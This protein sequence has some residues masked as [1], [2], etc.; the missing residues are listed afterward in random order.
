MIQTNV[1]RLLAAVVAIVCISGSSAYP[2]IIFDN[3]GSNICLKES[4]SKLILHNAAKVK[5]WE[6]QSI[7]KS[8]GNNPSTAWTES[9]ASGVAIGQ[10][11]DDHKPSTYFV[12][13]NSNAIVPL[14]PTNFNATIGQRY[15]AGH[16]VFH[17]GEVPVQGFIRFNDGFTV[18]HNASATW[19]SWV[20]VRGGIDLRETGTLIL[21]SPMYLGSGFTFTSGGNIVGNSS[22]IFMGGD[23]TLA[24]TGG[25]RVIHIKNNLVID[26]G[27]S[28]FNVGSRAQLFVD[29][30]VSLTLRNLTL[31][32]GPLS[33]ATPAVKLGALTS[34]LT[35]DNVVFELGSDY[36]FGG[37]SLFINNDVMVT[38]TSAFIYSA[39]F[40]SY[41]ASHSTWYFD[42]GTTL[43]IAPITHTLNRANV[44][45]P[46][47]ENDFI[48]MHD[49][50]SRLFLN[51]ASLLSTTTGLRLTR[52]TL[53]LDNKV[54]MDSHAERQLVGLGK[55]V[56]DA[57]T[58][59]FPYW[60]Y[61]SPDGRYL[62]VANSSDQNMQIFAFNGTA[63]TLVGQLPT[64]SDVDSINWSPDGRFIAVANYTAQQLEIFTFSGKGALRRVGITPTTGPVNDVTWSPDCRY[65]GVV[66]DD[67]I[68]TLQIFAFNG[69]TINLVGT[70]ATE[71]APYAVDWAPDG[72]YLV[73]VNYLSNSGQ[74]FAFMG[75][76]DPVLVLQLPTDDGP[77]DVAVSPDGTY[78]A[79]AC[80][81]GLTV[82][83]FNMAGQIGSSVSPGNTPSG[84]GWS[85]TGRYI[86]VPC[87]FDNT[88]SVY[89]FDPGGTMQLI[90]SS[91][92]CGAGAKFGYFS[93]DGNHIAVVASTDN[94][95]QLFD[96]HYGDGIAET[97]QP[98]TNAINFGHAVKGPDYDLNVRM[99][100]GARVLVT[101]Q[102]CDDSA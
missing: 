56:P 42:Y 59:Q 55:T 70:V 43:S 49:V 21:H 51:G 25:Y 84:V 33:A 95:L 24:A 77:Y 3:F 8:Y 28:V 90:G 52:G 66:N 20:P 45:N 61:W 71:S 4:D 101:G 38:G 44:L 76:A 89:Q 5:G 32:T 17:G 93:P 46:S 36:R 86:A 63:L 102:V 99:L 87:D 67:P 78:A 34:H 74:L 81:G 41:I 18:R 83:V 37:G 14:L 9:Y 35:L 1:L 22:T 6:Q 10:S 80:Y 26:G 39:P 60:A 79:I 68:N 19:D 91:V 94:L 69:E 85:P 92:A 13:N 40:R 64:S 73:V 16:V 48:V 2:T 15:L 27:G 75:D 31:R 23:L 62:A 57:T 7:I 12:I 72:S 65:V 54:I 98:W 47:L 30:N 97:T 100:S 82:Q 11:D 88:L 29:S 96:V 58:G 53:L 50:T